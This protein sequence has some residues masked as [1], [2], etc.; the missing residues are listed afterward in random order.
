[1]EP[2][3]RRL[4][5][6]RRR[7]FEPAALGRISRSAAGR[8]GLVLGAGRGSGPKDAAGL[9]RG[10][11]GRRG[12]GMALRAALLHAASSDAGDSRGARISKRSSRGAG[13]FYRSATDSGDS[14]RP[15]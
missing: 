6:F 15:P 11:V 10:F 12:D 7:D 1:M 3:L 8:G 2:A 5:T 13:A 4:T 9:V 14:F